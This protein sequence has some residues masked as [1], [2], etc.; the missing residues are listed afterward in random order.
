MKRNADGTI[1]RYKA[2]LVAR[3]FTQESG[4]DYIETFS[5]VIKYTIIRIII[6]LATIHKWPIRQLDISNAFLHGFLDKEIYITQPVGFIDKIHPNFVYKLHKSLYGLKQA[7][8]AW[9]NRLHPYL[10][11][12]GFHSSQ[13]NPSLFIHNSGR[14]K[15]YILV[16]VDDILV[17]GT[18]TV[19][20]DNFITQLGT[21]FPVR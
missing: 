21:K 19:A 3:G 14:N 1:Q 17:I 9:F 12:L 8:R 15:I 10:I 7:P 20:L 16:Y 2:R 4:V 11:H 13:V 6:A 18:S 5:L